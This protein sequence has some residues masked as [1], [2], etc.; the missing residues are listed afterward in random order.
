MYM[1]TK[2]LVFVVPNHHYRACLGPLQG[3]GVVLLKY[4]G[5]TRKIVQ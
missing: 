3:Y 4:S 5:F 1:R 2:P